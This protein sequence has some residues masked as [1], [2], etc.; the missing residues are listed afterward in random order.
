M[1]VEY[2]QQSTLENHLHYLQNMVHIL[3]SL[4][5]SMSPV[6]PVSP[7]S[8]VS[9]VS[10]VIQASSDELPPRSPIL[11]RRNA[12][13]S[14][15][16]HLAQTISRS[17]RN[18]IVDEL[19]EIFATVDIDLRRLPLGRF[20]QLFNREYEDDDVN[21]DVM[22]DEDFTIEINLT[23]MDEYDQYDEEDEEDEEDD[24]APYEESKLAHAGSFVTVD[25]PV[26]HCSICFENFE[27]RVFKTRCNHMFHGPCLFEWIRKKNNCPVCRH[28]F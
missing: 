20:R 22:D 16:D 15:S 14:Y 28:K 13:S 2:N 23:V 25:D 7:V 10:Q 5:S 26:D 18:L 9:Q 3:N 11:R 6:S 21:D 4:S 8:Q 17:F 27:T 1:S 12:M 24:D 19:E